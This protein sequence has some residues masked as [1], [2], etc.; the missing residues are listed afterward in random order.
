MDTEPTGSKENNRPSKKVL[1]CP[2]DWGLGHA[3][4]CIPIIQSLIDGGADVYIAGEGESMRLLAD[5]FPA[6]KQLHLKGYRIRFSYRW[7]VGTYLMFNLP[8]LI[9][10]IT[11]EHRELNKLIKTYG[12]DII[13]SDN[14]YGLWSKKVYTVFITHQLN[15][16]PPPSFKYSASVLRFITRYFIKK[17][18]ACWVPDVEEFPGLSGNLSHKH[19][20]PANVKYVGII[21]R[22]TGSNSVKKEENAYKLVAILSGPEPQRGAFEKILRQQLPHLHVKSLLIRG[23]NGTENSEVVNGNL[24]IIDYV[25]SYRL[26][27]LY[28]NSDVIICRGGY[29]TLMDLSVNGNKVICVPTPGQSEQ[30]YLSQLM[31]QQGYAVYSPQKD[32]NVA[33]CYTMVNETS[34]IPKFK[35]N[36]LTHVISELLNLP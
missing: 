9:L 12:F 4:R 6:V 21:S 24:T 2:L 16:I 36:K 7:S 8:R 31:A 27:S 5:E 32:F 1:L 10:R 34:G 22:L 30:E 11:D 19:T 13:I 18:S 28:I 25:N 14:R 3:T 23:I 20:I 33:E 26:S 35:G 17:Y 15:I 29:S